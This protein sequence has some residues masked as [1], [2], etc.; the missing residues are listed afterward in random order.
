M[1]TQAK[2]RTSSSARASSSRAASKSKSSSSSKSR[3]HG[4]SGGSPAKSES[5]SRS[6]PGARTREMSR[7]KSAGDSR[8]RARGKGKVEGAGQMTTDH[9][10]IRQWVEARRGQPACVRGTGG[11]GDTGML[12]I[13][14]P[15]YTGRDK[16]QPIP[17]DEW[18][19][20]F[21]EKNLAFLYQD[22]TKGGQKS[23]FNKLVSRD[24]GR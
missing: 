5:R 22:Q 1:A 20:K 12:R 18:F 3:S 11:R 15:G 17:W 4:R 13:D 19:D 21:E 16:L 7:S 2:K 10:Q 23:N 9:E 14:M 24:S 8:G 6:H